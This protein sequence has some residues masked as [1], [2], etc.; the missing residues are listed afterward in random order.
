M[1]REPNPNVEK[2][3]EMYKEGKSLTDIAKKL[4]IAEG[5]VR[6]WKSRYKWEDKRNVAKN[7]KCNVAK[8]DKAETQ[9]CKKKRG[10]PKGNQNS[11]GHSAGK[12]NPH[13]IPPLKHGGYSNV[14]WDTLSGEEKELIDTMP[15]DEETMLI[16]Q[17]KVFTVRERRIMM[18][19][20][21]YRDSQ[22]P[23]AI[24]NVYRSEQKRMFDTDEDKRLYDE[25]QRMKIAADKKLPGHAY[26]IQT[27]TENKDNIIAR[28]ESELSNVQAKKTR[29]I[30]AL[31]KLNLEKEKIAGESR[32]NEVVK[33]WAQ[34]V[35]KSRGENNG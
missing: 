17:I 20:N 16:D 27:A 15:Q 4:G 2:A 28:L 22:E 25:R 1:P 18:A 7:K 8:K 23:V 5:T 19:I 6:S 3:F 12:G 30:E 31:V 10:A 11:K 14:Y 34:Q 13:P 24:S 9:R 32:S 35:I 26:Q 29:A 21:K 33:A